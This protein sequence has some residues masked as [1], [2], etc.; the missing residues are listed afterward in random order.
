MEFGAPGVCLR[1]SGDRRTPLL[2]FGLGPACDGERM[3]KI[4]LVLENE[5]PLFR[6]NLS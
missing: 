3:P 4:V 2:P 1:E 5:S 6:S